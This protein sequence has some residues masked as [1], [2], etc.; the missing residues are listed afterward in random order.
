MTDPDA[1]RAKVVRTAYAWEELKRADE[2]LSRAELAVENA[3]LAA[4]TR[5]AP[6][7]DVVYRIRDLCDQLWFV[8]Y[9]RCLD[10]GAEQ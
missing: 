8:C 6:D 7:L 9:R 5:R 2:Q 1:A 10:E 4:M 3:R